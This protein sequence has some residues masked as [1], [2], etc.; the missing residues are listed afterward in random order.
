MRRIDIKNKGDFNKLKNLNGNDMVFVKFAK[1]ISSFQMDAISLKQFK[2]SLMLSFEEKEKMRVF[3]INVRPNTKRNYFF[4][5]ATK[6]SIQI[7]PLTNVRFEYIPKV[8]S[9]HIKKE[10]EL[11][12]V[13]NTYENEEVTVYLEQDIVLEKA[14][15]RNKKIKVIGNYHKLIVKKGIPLEKFD[16]NEMNLLVVDEIVSIY[17]AYDLKKCENFTDEVVVVIFKNGIMNENIPSI[18][19]KNFTGTMIVLG[20]HFSIINSNIISSSKFMGLFSYIHPYGSLK[21][22]DLNIKN[23]TFH[24]ENCTVIGGFLGMSHTIP[25]MYSSPLGVIEM[26]GCTIQNSLF[27]SSKFENVKPFIGI[28]CSHFELLSCCCENNMIKNVETEEMK[29]D[30]LFYY[31]PLYPTEFSKFPGIKKILEKH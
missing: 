4:E 19:L 20:N 9:F 2:G 13:L 5:D 18:E 12:E 11:K 15:I 30:A 23:C 7:D 27:L 3:K 31:E 8:L 25:S 26:N 22:Y 16:I 14:N 1:E 24:G 17:Q 29:E 21:I 28:E 6:V 10:N